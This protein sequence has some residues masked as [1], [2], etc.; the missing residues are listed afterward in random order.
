MKKRSVKFFFL[1]VLCIITFLTL[2]PGGKM[3]TG[4]ITNAENNKPPMFVLQ[5]GIE[6]YK[7]AKYPR[8]KGAKFDIEGM[9]D[10]LT[11]ERFKVP[12]ENIKTLMDKDATKENIFAAY[13][14]YLT[15]RAREYF[16]KTGRRDAVALFQFSG[17]GSQT[18]D[19]ADKDEA[20]GLDETLVT[21]NSEDAPGKNF[22]IT[23]DE[24][25]LLTKRLGKYTDNIVYILDS[26]HS[27]SGTRDSGDVRRVQKRTSLPVSVP[28]FAENSRSTVETPRKNEP[29]N[30]QTDLLP[31]SKDYIVISAA[32]A[33]QLAGQTE[34][35]E[36]ES[37][38][39]SAYYGKLTF[40][41]LKG[42]REA[43]PETT[44]REL[45]DNVT[46]EVTA[47]FGNSQIPQIEGEDRREVFGKLSKI[48]DN[49]IE[50]SKADA[51]QITLEAGA[52]QGVLKG[53]I[54]N[55][56]DR[57]K[58]KIGTAK[59]TLAAGAKS[60]ALI[61]NAERA[62]TTEDRAAIVSQGLSGTPLNVLLDGEEEAKLTTGD[63]KM[64]Q[65]LRQKFTSEKQVENRAQI[66][67]FASGK[68]NNKA[69]R[70]DA[71]LLKDKFSKVFPDQ[72]RAAPVKIRT[73]ENGRGVYEK[74]PA[75][76]RQVFYLAGK[77]F[78]PLYGFFVEAGKE[79]TERT[80]EKALIQLSRLRAVK[81]IANNRSVLR[82][83]VTVKP[84]R[85]IEP[86]ECGSNDLLMSAR[87]EI[88]E[89]NPVTR[90][91]K[92][93]K[94]DAFWL[95]VRNMSD[96]DLYITLLDVGSD[97]SV[98]ILFPG[99]VD[100][101]KEGFKL[102]AGTGRKIVIGEN[103]QDGVPIYMAV[104]PPAGIETFKLIATTEK[105]PRR[106]FEFLEMT[107]INERT[108]GEEET[109]LSVGDWTTDEI[110]FEIT[111]PK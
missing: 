8:L 63:Q 48:E 103:C 24:I 4:Q 60:T 5:V 3:Q 56:F 13:E 91:Y 18:P 70:W 44:Y 76:D 80:I 85:L 54:L 69:T 11:G 93:K 23:D 94:G 59:I 61:V 12:A 20:D 89:F 16:E 95:D 22:D 36:G 83:K 32:R 29:D 106:N 100:G 15:L 81:S 90:A 49:T 42:L 34:I 75:P 9:R 7:S 102:A 35:F 46:R 55:I 26:C 109:L 92:F 45:M 62:V 99:N 27:G 14:K 77:D 108:R 51:K 52:M 101:E 88:P 47:R 33:E 72:T 31:L 73:D 65:N 97:G 19:G 82:G 43:G 78:V 74:L 111:M 107:S 37:R 87:K 110:N 64:F 1:P 71:A 10:L 67:N 105:T 41:L 96:K 86:I 84:V 6:N 38:Y 21:V 50:I 53:T 79:Y 104:T 30:P 66:V 25:Y 68:W 57:Q 28:M 98:Q 58:K 39:P 17:H 2:V 40:S